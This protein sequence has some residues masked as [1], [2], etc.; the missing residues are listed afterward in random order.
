M[1]LSEETKLQLEVWA[2]NGL[3]INDAEIV[4]S[5]F[6]KAIQIETELNVKRCD[7]TPDAL[8]LLAS[9]AASSKTLTELE[10]YSVEIGEHA[11]DVAS[12][13]STSESINTLIMCNNQMGPHAVGFAN[14][15]A[16]SESI[17]TLEVTN[18]HMGEHAK[19]FVS[20]IIVS[21]TITNLNISG[22]DITGQCAE[23]FGNE[24]AAH[25]SILTSLNISHNKLIGGGWSKGSKKFQ[26]STEAAEAFIKTIAARLD[27]NCFTSE[28]EKLKDLFEAEQL[29]HNELLTP[30]AV[31]LELINYMHPPLS[32][33]VTDYLFGSNNEELNYS[34]SEIDCSGSGESADEADEAY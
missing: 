24:I 14:A 10:M 3:G 2:K 28:S 1:D 21:K 11:V 20:A 9:I 25:Q 19:D 22:N 5:D 4:E 17:K 33:V 16:A 27:L 32:C 6:Y 30:D 31:Q 13:I 29:Q 15:I 18:N 12:I 7:L 26:E 23:S 8:I 34:D